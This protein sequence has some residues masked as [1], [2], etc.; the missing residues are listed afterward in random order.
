MDVCWPGELLNSAR[1]KGKLL[2]L[3]S[4]VLVFLEIFNGFLQ[5][6]R[7]VWN[8]AVTSNISGSPVFLS[9]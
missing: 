8:E 4:Q 1:R 2:Q 9:L 3:W 7:I 6:N 5:S